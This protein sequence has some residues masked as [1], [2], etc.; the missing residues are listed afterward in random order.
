MQAPHARTRLLN[1]SVS[2]LPL[3]LV[4]SVCAVLFE[5][6]IS[7]FFSLQGQSYVNDEAFL[8]SELGEEMLSGQARVA[9]LWSVPT[10]EEALTKFG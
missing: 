9:D 3:S 8:D 7:I 6:T 1:I 10:A 5:Y 4:Q 2:R